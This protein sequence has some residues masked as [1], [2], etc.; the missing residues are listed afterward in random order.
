MRPPIRKLDVLVD[1]D[2]DFRMMI[3]EDILIV[4]LR[5]A[6]M[7]GHR[8]TYTFEEFREAVLHGKNVVNV[9]ER[10]ITQCSQ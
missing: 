3:S 9:E 5:E 1:L 10:V 2:D 8:R 4:L 7:S 6:F